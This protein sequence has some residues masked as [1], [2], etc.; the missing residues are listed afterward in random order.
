[1]SDVGASVRGFGPRR[2]CL[3]GWVLARSV[4]AYLPMLVRGYRVDASTMVPPRSH[5]RLNVG[6]D[7][8]ARRAVCVELV[9][10]GQKGRP[11]RPPF[12]RMLGRKCSGWRTEARSSYARDLSVRTA[13]RAILLRVGLRRQS[14]RGGAWTFQEESNHLTAGIGTFGIGVPSRRAPARPS[15]TR[16]VKHPLLKHDTTTVVSVGAAGVT[17][18]RQTAPA[19]DR[20]QLGLTLRLSDDLIS[21]Y[22][23]TVLSGRRGTRWIAEDAGPAA[24][25]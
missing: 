2:A 20:A 25:R 7:R 21:V 9:L 14:S 10:L 24:R 4:E 5:D 19:Y 11:T 23:F 17:D 18:A 6:D 16:S 22:G 3:L 15:M 13:R 12:S 8:G 1:M